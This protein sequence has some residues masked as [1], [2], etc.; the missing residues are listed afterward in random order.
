MTYNPDASEF[1]RIKYEAVCE[2]YR[3]SVMTET[4][5]RACLFALG[6]RGRQIDDEVSYQ[7]GLKDFQPIGKAAQRVV[8]KLSGV[9]YEFP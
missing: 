8:N 5:F 6:Y 1:K 4:V 2:G 9:F 3:E 7:N